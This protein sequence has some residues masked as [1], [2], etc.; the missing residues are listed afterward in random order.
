MDVK[1]QT[2]PYSLL[3]SEKVFQSLQLT[4]DVTQ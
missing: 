3:L 4:I 2:V 1:L